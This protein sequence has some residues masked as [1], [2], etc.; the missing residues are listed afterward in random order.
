MADTGFASFVSALSQNVPKVN[1]P[2]EDAFYANILGNFMQERRLKEQRGWQEEQ[3]EKGYKQ[4]MKFLGAQLENQKELAGRQYIVKYMTE[5]PPTGFKTKKE[6]EDYKKNIMLAYKFATGKDPSKDIEALF[7]TV[8]EMTKPKKE[9]LFSKLFNWAAGKDK[10]A[11]K[12]FEEQYNIPSSIANQPEIMAAL[13]P[14]ATPTPT[15]QNFMQN[16]LMDYM[17][18]QQFTP[19]PTPTAF[20]PEDITQAYFNR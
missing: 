8:D 1:V 17:T 20:S 7:P 16:Q 19:T 2:N 4:Q 15:P 11:P 12:T 5:N 13:M 3:T 6:A 10:K 18:G 14:Q 9:G